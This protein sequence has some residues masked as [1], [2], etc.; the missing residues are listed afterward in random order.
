MAPIVAARL[1]RKKYSSIPYL[2]LLLV[3]LTFPTSHYFTAVYQDALF[4]FLGSATLLMARQRRWAWAIIGGA[5]ATLARL[6]GLTLFFFLGAEYMQHLVPALRTRWQWQDP[7]IAFWQA[8]Q[9]K[10]IRKH[11]YTV[12]FFVIPLTFWGT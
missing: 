6:N 3:L 11:V 12:F 4:L 9:W 1:P 7:F 5:L 10:N 2:G 8:L